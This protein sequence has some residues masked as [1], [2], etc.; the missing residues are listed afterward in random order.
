MN[1]NFNYRLALMACAA[2]LLAVTVSAKTYRMT[3][4]QVTPGATGT[5]DTKV[6]KSGGNTELGVKV[7]HLARPTLLTP[8]ANDY[9]V[10]IEPEG[11]PAM[12][13]GVLRIGDNEKGDL[14]VTTSA[15]KFNVLVTAETEA[16]PQRPSNRVVLRSQVAE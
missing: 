9:V 10:W 1:W 7:D 8:P 14:T 2:L 12:N 6:D 15:S 5:I 3:S 4:T 13:E 16:H 11:Q